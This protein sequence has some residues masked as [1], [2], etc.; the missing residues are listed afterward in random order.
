MDI[1]EVYRKYHNNREIKTIAGLNEYDLTRLII[2]MDEKIK[3][4]ENDK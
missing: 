3:E 4:L 1:E 2:Y